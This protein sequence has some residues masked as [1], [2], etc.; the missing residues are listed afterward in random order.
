MSIKRARVVIVVL[1]WNG[2]AF[3][4]PCLDSLLQ[5]GYPDYQIVVVDNGSTDDSRQ[6]LANFQRDHGAAIKVILNNRNLGFA[7]G[8]NVGINYALKNRFDGVALFNNDAVADKDWLSN[9]AKVLEEKKEVGIVTGLLLNEDGSKIDS[10]GDFYSLW[11]L[12]F[13]RRREEPAANAPPSG[14]VFGATGGASLYRRELFE[15]VGQFDEDFF[16]YYEDVDIS[17]RAQLSGW[18]VYYT[19][20]AVAY[21]K[22]GETSKRIPGF[23]KYQMFKNLPQL[24]VK[25]VPRELI[26]KIG[27]RFKLIYLLMLARGIFS[28]DIAASLRGVWG[29]LLLMPKA[30]AKRPKIQAVTKVSSAY[31]NSIIYPQLPPLQGRLLRRLIARKGSATPENKTSR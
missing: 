25:N 28:K 5:Q 22:M 26:F 10:T 29:A 13:P 6:L 23:G 9:L 20:D 12:A 16:A 14:Y 27:W 30:F 31:I 15:D 3:I 18:K 7:G 8:I 24:F 1:N 11:G 21:H 4:R 19:K 17:F 2:A